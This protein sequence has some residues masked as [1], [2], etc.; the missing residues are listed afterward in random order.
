MCAGAGR[1]RTGRNGRYR[2]ALTV[3]LQIPQTMT[4]ERSVSFL[5]KNRLWQVGESTLSSFPLAKQKEL[6]SALRVELG[7]SPEPVENEEGIVS[8]L[9]RLKK[10][11]NDA[12]NAHIASVASKLVN[13]VIQRAIELASANDIEEEQVET[14]HTISLVAFN[15]NKLRLCPSSKEQFGEEGISMLK[16]W[17]SLSS[18]LVK[19]DIVLLTEV[20]GAPKTLAER[21]EIFKKL[22]WIADA[23]ADPCFLGQGHREFDRRFV[24]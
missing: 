13:S 14:G 18:V 10:R 12:D 6:H 7:L 22:L 8:A 1:D 5:V 9:L 11:L 4:L 21:I 20:P 23:D 17:M 24:A 3:I 16:A 19:Y 2:S 15:A